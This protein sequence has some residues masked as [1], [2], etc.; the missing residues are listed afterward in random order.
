[1]AVVAAEKAQRSE[2]T[3]TT[4]AVDKFSILEMTLYPAEQGRHAD[5]SQ[6]TLTIY[7]NGNPIPFED[8]LNLLG[9]TLEG[10]MRFSKHAYLMAAKLSSRCNAVKALAGRKFGPEVSLAPPTPSV[11]GSLCFQGSHRPPP[12]CP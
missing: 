2:E 10:Q 6:K 1:M 9:F 3:L 7:L 11:P 12:E 8:N 5:G 4:I